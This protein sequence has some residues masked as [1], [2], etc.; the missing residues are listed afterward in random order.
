MKHFLAKWAAF[1]LI[2]SATLVAFAA[3]PQG[4]RVTT[5]DRNG[6]GRPDVW[7][8]YDDRGAPAEVGIDTNFDGR[9]DVQ[10]Y[11]EH[12]TLIR[13]ESDRNF[14]DRVDLVE[15]FDAATHERVRS[16]VDLDYDGTADL[17]VL[18]QDGRPV[19]SKRISVLA[20]K[21]LP[22]NPTQ[23]GNTFVH[24]PQLLR[25]RGDVDRLAPLSDPFRVDA[26]IR[27]TN[28]AS[29]GHDNVGLSTSG[30]L[31]ASC[32]DAV[33]PVG[34]PARFVARDLQASALAHLSVQSPRGPPLS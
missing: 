29:S 16:I 1:C 2:A 3:W 8:Q 15:E 13:R 12:G 9:S 4:P 28:A 18:F 33:N 6:D 5:E 21:P 23:T 26:T 20:A 22:V 25:R 11:Y 19:F 32:I 34:P 27:G 30:G 31:P 17:L 24:Q 10:E 7:R 14:D